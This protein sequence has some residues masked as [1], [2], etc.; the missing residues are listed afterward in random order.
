MALFVLC[1]V[2]CVGGVVVF[3]GVCL[4]VF[5]VGGPHVIYTVCLFKGG[6]SYVRASSGLLGYLVWRFL[7]AS[8]RGPL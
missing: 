7:L 8:G 5:Y 4:F 1:V 6:T 3:L 2:L